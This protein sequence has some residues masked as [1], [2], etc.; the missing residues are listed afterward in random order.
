MLT[1]KKRR[2]G[3]RFFSSFPISGPTNFVKIS[4]MSSMNEPI[5]AIVNS[6]VGGTHDGDGRIREAEIAEPLVDDLQQVHHG[7]E[8]VSVQEPT[9]PP[10]DDMLNYPPRPLSSHPI[11]KSPDEEAAP[12]PPDF[13]RRGIHIPLRTR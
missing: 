4:G 5:P 1:K 3:H 12:P 2:S 7:K 13:T 8:N 11:Q 9:A 6:A 10:I